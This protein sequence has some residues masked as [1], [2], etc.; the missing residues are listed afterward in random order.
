MYSL[1]LSDYEFQKLKDITRRWHKRQ[2]KSIEHKENE[3]LVP[4][5]AS[6]LSY[7]EEEID[8]FASVTNELVLEKAEREA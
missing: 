3:P 1:K 7:L 6:Y 2:K 4:S 5:C 8:E